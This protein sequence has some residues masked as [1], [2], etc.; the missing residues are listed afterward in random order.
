MKRPDG[1]P[2]SFTFV[3]A[4]GCELPRLLDG[5]LPGLLGMALSPIKKVAILG[6]I[7]VAVAAMN[8]G[9]GHDGLL[10]PLIRAS[11]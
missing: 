6:R 5:L 9:S 8:S 4:K 2:G 10:P 11:G 7:E 3:T 1:R